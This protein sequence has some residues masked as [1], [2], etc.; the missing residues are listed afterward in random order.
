MGR[1]RE[2]ARAPTQ[3]NYACVFAGVSISIIQTVPVCMCVC[4]YVS[5]RV[6]MFVLGRNAYTRM[7]II[8]RSLTIST[9]PHNRTH[10]E[11]MWNG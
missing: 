4:V 2:S 3:L 1:E 6:F 9:V 8:S 10:M 7:G 5:V 11:L